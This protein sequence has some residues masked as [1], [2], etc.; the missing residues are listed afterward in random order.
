MRATVVQADDMPHPMLTWWDTK[1]SKL[2]RK[3]A[4]FEMLPR[5]PPARNTPR[6]GP[7]FLPQYGC[8]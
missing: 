8:C 2:I 1:I 6:S 3:V 4:W 7:L 5:T